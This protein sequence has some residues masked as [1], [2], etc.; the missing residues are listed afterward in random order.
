[1][2]DDT[3]EISTDSFDLTRTVTA[4]KTGQDRY[5]V[6]VLR[7]GQ[8]TTV[9]SHVWLEYKAGVDGRATTTSAKGGCQLGPAQAEPGG[10][11]L[12]VFGVIAMGAFAIERRRRRPQ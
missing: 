9:T 6:E 7:N 1:M 12:A 8:V 2:P 11:W 10:G 5:R 4:P 3:K